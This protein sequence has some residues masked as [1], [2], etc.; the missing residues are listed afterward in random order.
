VPCE[1]KKK[2]AAAGEQKPKPEGE[3]KID[4]E[5]AEVI[6]RVN[7]AANKL[8]Q[9]T[10]SQG[11]STNVKFPLP[12][13]KVGSIDALMSLS[14]DMVKLDT[15]LMQLTKKIERNF[16]DMRKA[17]PA[18]PEPEAGGKKVKP[19]KLPVELKID[20][21][22]SSSEYV[23]QFKWNKGLYDSTL[24]LSKLKEKILDETTAVDEELRHLTS[25]YAELRN[26]L[27]AIERKEG[28]SL[29]VKS[30]SKYIK[31]GKTLAE[32]DLIETD[33][34]TTLLVIV[35]KARK[36][37]FLTTYESI[38]VEAAEKL[39]ADQERQ[40]EQ[41]EKERKKR[42]EALAAT[43]KASVAAN[44][45]TE[46]APE[47]AASPRAA[48]RTI[49]GGKSKKLPTPR[50]VVPRSAKVLTKD[51]D[52][53]EFFLIR[54]V[55]FKVPAPEQKDEQ[56]GRR[57]ISNIDLF[58]NACRDRKFTIRPYKFDENE[59][60]NSAKALAALTKKKRDRWEHLVK[61][62][63]A[64]YDNAFK[65]WIHVKSMRAFVESV[66][67][68]GISNDWYVS[69]V[70][71]NRGYEK[72]VRD[73]LGELYKNLANSSLTAALDPNEVDMSGFGA[74]FYPYVYIPIELDEPQ[75]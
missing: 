42:E 23:S 60:A 5:R 37:E 59:D 36:E 26:A 13:F 2:K 21:K 38:E 10:Q 61:W 64:Q 32:S 55:C 3:S 12:R 63:H 18:L 73:V 53:A 50:T 7:A 8:N 22:L 54:V 44:S 71:P 16:V 43:S 14:D 70:K 34:F 29:M 30:L 58:K 56:E 24:A 4:E 75:V 33:K 27:S 46:E 72:N 62:C 45:S 74:D 15:S 67:R 1:Q 49:G 57:F 41:Q 51:E 6:K 52:D 39:K 31:Q 28:G 35:P 48:R 9:A 47:A 17:P 40:K 69:L 68:F 20:D 11:Y 19:P 66:L 25:E 65:A